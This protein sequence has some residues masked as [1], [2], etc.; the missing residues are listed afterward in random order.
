MWK[1]GSIHPFYHCSQCWR[2]SLDVQIIGEPRAP[3]DLVS[4]QGPNP[5]YIFSLF[6]HRFT[7]DPL[8]CE[9]KS[10]APGYGTFHPKKPPSPGHQFSGVPLPTGTPSLHVSQPPSGGNPLRYLSP[11]TKAGP[12]SCWKQRWWAFS[13]WVFSFFWFTPP[14]FGCC[15]CHIP[16]PAT[17]AT[18]SMAAHQLER[19]LTTNLGG[20]V[21]GP[22]KGCFQNVLEQRLWVWWLQWFF[23]GQDRLIGSPWIVVASDSP[24][25][26]QEHY[27]QI[28]PNQNCLNELV[29]SFRKI[30]RKSEDF[31]KYIVILADFPQ[32][33]L[34][35]EIPGCLWACRP[36]GQ[37]PS[38]CESW[39]WFIGGSLVTPLLRF[40]TYWPNPNMILVAI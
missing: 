8:S 6:G 9:S 7:G 13:S 38:Y 5:Q 37:A 40:H 11:S 19:P 24:G 31:A 2:K 23:R 22:T 36:A 1:P 28:A 4:W 17:A 15:W 35:I 32:T 10:C 39:P 16:H 3:A 20:S 27:L 34:Q 25:L 26:L 14:F 18:G 30:Y 33:L 29:L 21:V 12:K